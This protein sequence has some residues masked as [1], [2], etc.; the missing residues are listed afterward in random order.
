[1]QN[2]SNKQ[3][4]YYFVKVW[5]VK[6]LIKADSSINALNKVIEMYPAYKTAYQLYINVE[7]AGLEINCAF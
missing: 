3:Q 5:L 6:E 4:Y 2:W 7:F 1:M